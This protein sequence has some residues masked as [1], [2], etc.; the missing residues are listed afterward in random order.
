MYSSG[1][2]VTVVNVFRVDE[3]M[4]VKISDFGLCRDIYE[5]DYYCLSK[6]TIVPVKWMS[7]ESLHDC[8]Y[9]HQSDVVSEIKPKQL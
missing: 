5:N 6:N 9:T 4:T 1:Q 2:I 8:I 7:P 3:D